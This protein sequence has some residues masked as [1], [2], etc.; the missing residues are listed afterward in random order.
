MKTGNGRPEFN[1]SNVYETLLRSLNIYMPPVTS[2]DFIEQDL[3][4]SAFESTVFQ[5]CV[6]LFPRRFLPELLGMTLFVE[7]EATPTMEPIGQ[8]MAA[9]HID[10]QYYRMHA[11]IDNINVGHGALAK[12]AIKL[13]LHQK[14]QE[15]GDAVVQEHWQRIWRGY[16][17]W[18]TLGNGADEVIER[19]MIVDKK[20]IHL[21]SSLLLSDDILPPLVAALRSAR[22]PLSEHLRAGLSLP[23]RPCWRTG[24]PRSRRRARCWTACAGS[25]MSVCEPAST[26][27]DALPG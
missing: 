3:V 21:R 10:P 15:G 26:T 24:A 18:S 13:Y 17:A 12:E 6:G 4:R 22:E 11:A 8:M 14:E 25:S 2:R 19:M 23:T 27:S 20:Q 5:L 7:W 16:V 1:H 9:R